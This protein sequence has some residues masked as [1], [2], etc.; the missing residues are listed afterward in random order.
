M[1]NQW[2]ILL[3]VKIMSH[4]GEPYIDVHIFLILLLGRSGHRGSSSAAPQA[5][6]KHSN[7]LKY[8][9]VCQNLESSLEFPSE[10][11]NEMSFTVLNCGPKTWTDTRLEF[12]LCDPHGLIL[13]AGRFVYKET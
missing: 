4:M 6:V 10:G 1:L 3:M 5:P 13:N 12:Q 8:T 9:C 2:C 11:L 7:L